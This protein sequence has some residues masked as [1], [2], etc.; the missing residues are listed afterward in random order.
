M[1]QPAREVKDKMHV[2]QRPSLTSRAAYDQV[3]DKGRTAKYAVLP[4]LVDSG[5]FIFHGICRR[6]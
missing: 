4:F 2:R 6:K 1:S 5:F 3:T